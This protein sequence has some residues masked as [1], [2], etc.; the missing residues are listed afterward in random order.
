[1]IKRTGIPRTNLPKA[2]R[3]EAAKS[4][5]EIAAEL[6]LMLYR[7]AARWSQCAAEHRTFIFC[8]HHRHAFQFIADAGVYQRP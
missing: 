6:Q 5:A 1:M 3:W 7:P 4:R 8:Q 2:S